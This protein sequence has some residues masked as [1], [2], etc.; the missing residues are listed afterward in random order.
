MH[1]RRTPW[2]CRP[3]AGSGRQASYH[4][5]EHAPCARHTPLPVAAADGHVRAGTPASSVQRACSRRLLQAHTRAA[6]GGTHG[7]RACAPRG[8]AR[9][10]PHTRRAPPSSRAQLPTRLPPCSP[11]AGPGSSRT[12]G[13][14]GRRSTPWIEGRALSVCAWREAGGTESVATRNLGVTC[15]P[16]WLVAAPGKP[17]WP[18]RECQQPCP[19][20]GRHRTTQIY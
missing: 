8:P 16:T 2:S 6:S 15:T 1:R 17:L 14:G 7:R 4:V 12:G 3:P 18:G 20:I 19:P 13:R 10:C 11:A 5:A 9:R